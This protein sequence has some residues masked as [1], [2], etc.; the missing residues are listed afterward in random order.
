M[1]LPFSNGGGGDGQRPSPSG[2][3]G[4]NS[5]RT[6]TAGEGGGAR[7]W[8]RR[9]AEALPG[10]PGQEER[11]SAAC[12]AFSLS[13]LLILFL[14]NLDTIVDSSGTPSPRTS[15]SQQRGGDGSSSSN[16]NSMS[17]YYAAN[18]REQ[19]PLRV[20]MD[21]TKRYSLQF[22]SEFF[23]FVFDPVDLNGTTPVQLTSED[24]R[25]RNSHMSGN[26]FS[27]AFPYST[28]S[29]SLLTSGPATV[30]LYTTRTIFQSVRMAL[31]RIH[32]NVGAAFSSAPF[33]FPYGFFDA[34]S[35]LF[36]DRDLYLTGV[37][38][39]DVPKANFQGSSLASKLPVARG[40]SLSSGS[41]DATWCTYTA[42][43]KLNFEPGLG[44]SAREADESSVSE[45][46]QRAA[47]N[48]DAAASVA[49]AASGPPRRLYAPGASVV[50]SPVFGT[51]P[52]RH[53]E[54]SSASQQE[55]A[56]HSGTLPPGVAVASDFS[57]DGRRVPS[58]SSSDSWVTDKPTFEE[59]S[60]EV[61]SLNGEDDAGDERPRVGNEP[62]GDLV[63]E[64]VS[65]DC[66]FYIYFR[67]WEIDYIAL[68]SHITSVTLVFNVK[69]LLEMRL[70]WKQM[71][72]TEGIGG[73]GSTSSQALL[74]RVSVMGLAWQ[75]ALDIFEVVAMF[76]VAMNLQIMMAYFSILIMFK[77]ILFGALEVRYLLMVWNASHQSNPQDLD[78]TGRALA[79]FYRNFYGSLAFLVLFLYY[80]F[81]VF[82]PVCVVLYFVW[83]PQIAWDVW[84][85][86]RNSMDLQF[87]V[88]ISICRLVLPTY[89]FGCPVS[90]FQ[91][92]FVGVTLPNYPILVC[93]IVIMTLQVLLMLAQRRFGS[94]FF[95]PLDHLPHVYNYHRPLPASLSND[96]E[97]GLPE[98]AI[99]MNP[100]A[101]KSRHRSITPCD[102]L[103]HDK[104][105]QQWM[106]VKMECPNCRGALP[107]F[108]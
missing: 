20:G 24:L 99:C 41:P 5:G 39:R 53:R 76:R 67:A 105:L 73:L 21:R 70:F 26:D 95:V 17:A 49:A 77:A 34:V 106:E 47:Q 43:L 89:L 10:P 63:G 92:S 91:E 28:R 59:G 16:S 14:F 30:H 104:C 37:D 79:H 50:E 51:P 107:P 2:Q 42:S 56:T 46:S 78:S 19:S 52:S 58:N 1:H 84:R 94:R 85:G 65:S 93:I 22:N 74:Q 90:L 13:I 36:V 81:P 100:I 80:V 31:L 9:G 6:S 82:P 75:A 40:L 8:L 57:S 66:G 86:Q 45:L 54:G 83:L 98:C 64:L 12:I 69:T 108:P 25:Q 68:A 102:H 33:T 35:S 15:V 96:A 55:G 18:K 29:L 62:Q 60:S 61:E 4:G 88:G 101:R 23:F 7:N 3:G 32:L 38:L 87:V 44:K 72:H 103:F 11:S 71:Q 27:T 48:S 97:E